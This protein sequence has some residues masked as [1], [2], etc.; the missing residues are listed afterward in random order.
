MRRKPSPPV[1]ETRSKWQIEQ[2]ARCGCR[3]S[4]DYCPCQNVENCKRGGDEGS[5]SRSEQNPSV[6]VER[7]REALELAEGRLRCCAGVMRDLRRQKADEG[8]ARYGLA[9]EWADRARAA[10]S[11]KQEPGVPTPGGEG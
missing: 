8:L 3:G 11:R 1:P 5:Q 7:L 4:D 9:T 6:E 2:G 10:L